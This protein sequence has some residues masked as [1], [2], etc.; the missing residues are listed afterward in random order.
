[1]RPRVPVLAAA[2]LGADDAASDYAAVRAQL[3]AWARA[4]ADAL[5]PPPER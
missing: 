1:M 5:L 3:T 4:H 2:I